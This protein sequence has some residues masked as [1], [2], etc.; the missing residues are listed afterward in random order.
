MSGLRE[1]FLTWRHGDALDDLSDDGGGGSDQTGGNDRVPNQAPDG[2]HVGEPRLYRVLEGG[3]A[4]EPPVTSAYTRRCSHVTVQ[5]RPCAE[6]ATT[7]QHPLLEVD[8]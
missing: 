8:G 5:G 4:A 2:G 3:I 7:L 6:I 1:G